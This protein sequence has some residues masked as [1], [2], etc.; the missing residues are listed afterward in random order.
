MRCALHARGAPDHRTHP[1]VSRGVERAVPWIVLPRMGLVPH[2]AAIALIFV[3]MD[4]CNWF[5]HLA[6]H[7][8]ACS[9][10]STSCTIRKRT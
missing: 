1:V 6:N 10:V 5:V 9:G 2:G 8:C 4:T 7:R 3:A